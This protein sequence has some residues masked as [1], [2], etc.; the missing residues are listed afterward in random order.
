MLRGIGGGISNLKSGL[1]SLVKSS[2]V[3]DDDEESSEVDG[4]Q[5]FL[6]I[7]VL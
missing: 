5:R 7:I 3:E 4:N 1:K 2:E 6:P